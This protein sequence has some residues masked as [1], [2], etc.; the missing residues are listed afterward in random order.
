MKKIKIREA[1]ERDGGHSAVAIEGIRMELKRT[2]DIMDSLKNEH[3]K[4]AEV[5][6]TYMA[7]RYLPPGS[8]AYKQALR[9]I[10]EGAK[11]TDKFEVYV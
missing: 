2:N 11:C 9:K 1:Q 7:L 3:V 10:E 5:E 4:A 8:E 6:R